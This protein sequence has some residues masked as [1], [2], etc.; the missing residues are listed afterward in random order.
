LRAAALEK[1]DRE[2]EIDVVP[3]GE[4]PGRAR[5]VPRALEL[6]RSPPLD[7][8]DLGLLEKLKFRCRQRSPFW[9]D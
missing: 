3:N 8:L 7:S 2:V 5:R 9:A 4:A 6:F 1:G